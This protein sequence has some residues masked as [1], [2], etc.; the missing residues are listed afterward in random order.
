MAP[1]EAAAA[2][3]SSML[4]GGKPAVEFLER[5]MKAM[6]D[7]QNR[8]GPVEMLKGIFIWK[9]MQ[10]RRK[11][12]LKSRKTNGGSLISLPAD[13][14]AEPNNQL[15]QTLWPHKPLPTHGPR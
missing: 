6:N 3:K 9:P 10:R 7:G 5:A 2:L 14:P 15:E 11:L 4:K 12:R 8:T 1:G 13:P